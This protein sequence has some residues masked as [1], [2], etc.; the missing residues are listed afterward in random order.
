MRL[1][2]RLERNN[3]REEDRKK[4]KRRGDYEDD[5]ETLTYKNIQ[6]TGYLNAYEGVF[7]GFGDTGINNAPS[8]Y[9]A[10]AV[11]RTR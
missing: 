1:E 4:K 3:K 6:R 11:F 5:E 7:K 9:D 8:I 2:E 10:K